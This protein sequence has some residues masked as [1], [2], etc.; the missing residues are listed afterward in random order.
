[1]KKI[2]FVLLVTVLGVFL[3]TN[4]LFA[5][6]YSTNYSSYI[7]S[8][9]TETMVNID[10]S[11]S[12]WQYVFGTVDDF[13]ITLNG[14]QYIYDGGLSSSATINGANAIQEIKMGG[15]AIKTIILQGCQ[16]VYGTADDTEIN[17]GEQFVNGRAFNTTILSGTQNVDYFA[18]ADE[19]KILG[20][21]QKVSGLATNT[22]IDNNGMQIVF[23]GEARNTVIYNGT[24]LLQS[25]GEAYD[26]I[27][28]TGGLQEVEEDSYAENTLIHQDGV[29]KVHG[30][31]SNTIINDH[32]KQIVSTGAL[33]VQTTLYNCAIQDVY[34]GANLVDIFDISNQNVYGTASF[35]TIRDYGEQKVYGTA[36]NTKIL[37]NGLQEIKAGGS[38]YNTEIVSGGQSVKL[39]GKSFNSIVNSY[40]GVSGIAYNSIVINGGRQYVY[41]GG[42]LYS[43]IIN[44]YG[45]SQFVKNFGFSID[46][47][48]NPGSNLI[49]S[50]GAYLGGETLMKSGSTMQFN[51]NADIK[52]VDS[53]SK[54]I[55]DG[56]NID[57]SDKKTKLFPKVEGS[58]NIYIYS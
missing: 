44:G 8:G 58:G 35:T 10:G 21:E 17:G 12:R 25:T 26:T 9:S 7:A 34:G 3:S 20:G 39:G 14:M 16:V 57:V 41:G 47:V 15:K 4:I 48:F 27:I 29:Q 32:G 50:N 11:K 56:S 36:N 13:F 19:T 54:I 42:I 38:A 22:I 24:Q 31:V 43:S 18:S 45:S 30:R 46:S 49:L 40:Q 1:M 23:S 33:S 28:N 2:R 6:S 5:Q 37:D 52:A 51:E 53:N 55:M